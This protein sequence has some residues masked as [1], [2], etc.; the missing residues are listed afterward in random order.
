M[1]TPLTTT[2]VADKE[3]PGTFR[4]MEPDVPADE[5]PLSIYLQKEMVE[6]LFSEVELGITAIKLTLAAA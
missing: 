2:L 4:F 1:P 5:K 6:S 3:T